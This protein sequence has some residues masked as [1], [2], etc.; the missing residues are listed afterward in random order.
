MYLNPYMGG[1]LAQSSIEL[2]ETGMAGIRELLQQE[3]L[4][5][6]SSAKASDSHATRQ[7]GESR[8]GYAGGDSSSGTL[9]CCWAP[10]R[11]KSIQNSEKGEC[12]TRGVSVQCRYT[13]PRRLK[14]VVLEPISVPNMSSE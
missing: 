1:L 10:F 9:T 2:D 14:F 11:Q 13:L 6:A 12:S 3:N 5:R 8:G 7:E 4:A